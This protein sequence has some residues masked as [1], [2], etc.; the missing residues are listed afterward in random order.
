MRARFVGTQPLQGPTC[1]S[2]T[3]V[4]YLLGLSTLKEIKLGFSNAIIKAIFAW[5]APS[6]INSLYVHECGNEYEYI[7]SIAYPLNVHGVSWSSVSLEFWSRRMT[8][9]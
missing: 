2:E 3:C 1:N 9:R 6:F 8:T 7:K 5:L 4:S